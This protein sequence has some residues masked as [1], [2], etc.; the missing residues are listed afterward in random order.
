MH[1]RIWCHTFFVWKGL[2]FSLSLMPQTKA[3]F[4]VTLKVMKLH[5]E[6]LILRTLWNFNGRT[7]ESIHVKMFYLI[8]TLWPSMEIEFTLGTI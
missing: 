3:A 2:F 8:L 5:N 1:N 6:N 4:W 7:G